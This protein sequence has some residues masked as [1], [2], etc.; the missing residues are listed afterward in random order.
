MKRFLSRLCVGLFAT[1][2]LAGGSLAQ[3]ALTWQ[4][5]REKFEAANP[6]LQAGQIGI[7]EFRAQEVTAYLRP[8]P[9]LGL[10]LPHPI[11]Q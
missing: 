3:R 4:E 11:F 10:T 8:N 2:I 9:S 1:A 5:I 7:K 6:T